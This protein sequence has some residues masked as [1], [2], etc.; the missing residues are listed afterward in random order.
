MYPATPPASSMANCRCIVGLAQRGGQPPLEIG[1]AG[2]PLEQRVDGDDGVEVGAG[3]A[4]GGGF[5]NRG[6]G[7]HGGL[8]NVYWPTA[9]GQ[10]AE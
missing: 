2:L 6:S 7:V 9:G 10:P 4:P 8:G 5:A 1:A 3:E